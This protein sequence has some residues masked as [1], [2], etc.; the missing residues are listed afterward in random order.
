MWPITLKISLDHS[1][2]VIGKIN[3]KNNDIIQFGMGM[4]ELISYAF[5]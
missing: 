3:I 5:L 1:S 2:S 4:T